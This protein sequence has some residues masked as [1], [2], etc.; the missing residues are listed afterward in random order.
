MKTMLA[1]AT[2]AIA[3]CATGAQADNLLVNPGFETGALAPW[4]LG[5]SF[6]GGVDWAVTSTD[7]HSGTY[8]AIDT[9]NKELLQMIAGV[10]GSLVTE[11]SFWQKHPDGGS[12]PSYVEIF[13][14]DATSSSTIVYTD[15]AEWTFFNVTSLVNPSKTV[16]GL[17]IYG[18]CCA[19][20]SM[21]L[22]DDLKIE[23]RVSAVPEPASWAML[24]IGM[25]GVGG[26]MRRRKVSYS[27]A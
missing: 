14:S 24:T 26:Y 19:G 12:L 5:P 13:Y 25:F 15:S 1:V 21:T 8:S 4:A 18:Y 23:A 11:V 2:A 20:S 10:S 27:L 9:G 22:L 16:T 3:L 17:G 6:S 7:A